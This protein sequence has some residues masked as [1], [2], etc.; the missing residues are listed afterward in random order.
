M[1][2]STA[3]LV[4]A[5]IGAGTF[6]FRFSGIRFF[7]ARSMPEPLLRALRYV[8]AAVIAAIV[9]PAIVHGG[10]DPGFDTDNARLFAGLVAAAV[11]WT[12]RSVLLTLAAGMGSLWL[13]E[14]VL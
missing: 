13:I 10:P 9:A 4:I 7:G 11:A 6:A 5:V 12:S 14:W 3:W 1:S 2:E 8:P